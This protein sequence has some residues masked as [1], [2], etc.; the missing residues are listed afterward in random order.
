MA[1]GPIGASSSRTARWRGTTSC[2]GHATSSSA[3]VSD[4]VLIRADGSPLYTFTS[5][6]DDAD[7]GITHIIRGEDHVSNTAVQIDLFQA[8]TKRA[9]PAFRA[10]AADFGRGW[11]KTLQAHRLDLAEVAAQGRHRAGGDHRLSGAA[12]DQQGSGAAAAGGAG[13]EP[14]CSADSSRFTAAL[15]CQAPHRAEPRAVHH[16]ESTP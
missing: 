6:V 5:V 1:S 11:R 16:M 4:P 15:R 12:G 2:W 14:S 7:M 3:P 13:A 9:S 8:I 10:S